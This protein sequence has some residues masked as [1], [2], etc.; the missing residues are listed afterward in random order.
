MKAR[1]TA[2]K[3]RS[4][5]R[6]PVGVGVREPFD[7]LAD[8]F[9]GEAVVVLDG[10]TSGFEVAHGGLG[11]GDVPLSDRMTGPPCVLGLIDAECRAAGRAVDEDDAPFS[12]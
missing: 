6:L 8:P 12:W 10:H 9:P 1:L 5:T 2:A 11:I 3:R 4:F 7:V